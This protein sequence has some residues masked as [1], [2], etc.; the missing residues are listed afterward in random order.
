M[1][2][3]FIS[4]KFLFKCHLSVKPTLLNIASRPHLFLCS[5]FRCNT[6]RSL[7]HL[8]IMS[9]V[10]GSSPTC[11]PP[12]SPKECKSMRQR[13]LS[14]LFNEVYPWH[15]VGPQRR[16]ES[17]AGI[18]PEA[19]VVKLFSLSLTLTHRLV[20]ISLKRGRQNFAGVPTPPQ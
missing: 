14:L 9:R 11:A 12:L 15:V 13:P 6:H 5:S 1:T 2:H 18:V 19:E 8:F 3:A 17:A 20:S 7:T 10:H 16:D 4:F